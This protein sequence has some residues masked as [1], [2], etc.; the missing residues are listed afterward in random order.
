MSKK[1][2]IFIDIGNTNDLQRL[3]EFLN[4]LPYCTAIV[5]L[6]DRPKCLYYTDEI[7]KNTGYSKEEFEEFNESG[8]FFDKITDDEDKDRILSEIKNAT[9]EKKDFDCSFRY[10]DK[11]KEL[12][13]LQID[14][15]FMDSNSKNL[16]Y[17][18]T[19]SRPEE[20]ARLYKQ[21]VES[22]AFG[23]AVAERKTR[24]VLYINNYIL[25]S[26]F[27]SKHNFNVIG[28]YIEDMLPESDRFITRDEIDSLQLGKYKE[29]HR[30][31]GERLFEIRVGLINWNGADAY[32]AFIKDETQ[33][34]I[35]Q[36]RFSELLNSVPSGI[37][38][39]EVRNNEFNS[40]YLNDYFFNMIR[41]SR[42]AHEKL[43]AG[44]YIK[45]VHP[46]D[47]MTVRNAIRLLIE[48][49]DKYAFSYRQLCGDGKYIWLSLAVAVISRSKTAITA[50]CSYTDF[51]EVMQNR[52]VLEK[53]NIIIRKR[54][55]QELA[56]RDALQRHSLAFSSFNVTQNKMIEVKTN[57]DIQ[58]GM[59]SGINYDGMIKL[60][61]KTI[62]YDEDKVK[63]ET[64]LQ[65][66]NINKRFENGVTEEKVEYRSSIENK[67]T[68]IELTSNYF[69]EP[70][71]DDLIAYTF[72]RDIDDEKKTNIAIESVVDEGVD[73]IVLLKSATNQSRA[74][75]VRKEYDSPQQHLYSCVKTPPIP[76]SLRQM[77]E[78]DEPIVKEF[79][80]AE[81]LKSKLESNNTVS[82][83]YRYHSDN[84]ETMRKIAVAFYLDD[85]HDDIVIYI[86]DITDLYIEEQKNREILENAVDQANH[87]NEAKSEFLSRMSH[88][89]RTPM[90]GILGLTTLALESDNID[91][92]HKYL[93]ELNSSGT[94]LLGLLND[95]L[96]MSKI[97][98]GAI[99]LKPAPVDTRMFMSGLLAVIH[100]QAEEKGVIFE[101]DTDSS[102][103]VP[104]QVF[105]SLRVQQ[106]IMNIL[107]NAVK[108]TP[109]G[110]KVHYSYS[111]IETNGVIYCHHIISDTGIGM[112]DEFM[113]KMFDP[114]VQ[115]ENNSDSNSI[116]TGLGLSIC[117]KLTTIM[118]GTISVK[119]SIGKGSEFAVDIPT[120]I[121]SEEEYYEYTN[122]MFKDKKGEK[123][124]SLSGKKILICEDHP[125]NM[126]IAEKMLQNEGADVHTA[127]N[128]RLGV[129][130]F[131]ESPVGYY[132]CILM[133]IRMPVMDGLEAAKTIR[134]LKREDA[135]TVPVIAMSANVFPDDV[136]RSLDAGMNAHLGKPIEKQ[137]MISTIEKLI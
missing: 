52:H 87:A 50:Y 24:R 32:I 11:D 92:I 89:I 41:S 120:Q 31:K 49:M 27:D 47:V 83:T 57:N 100:A 69:K 56:R 94:Y 58:L 75:K 61:K 76:E 113:S 114:F 6:S 68:W 101:A 102:N 79:F 30:S 106:I 82:V 54:Y 112:S 39:Y 1:D 128:G 111:Y 55:E 29:Y 97:D 115:E 15:K 14:A 104:Y 71:T 127:T 59:V 66:K 124:S 13:W 64:F 108:F 93:L 103:D 22:S 38:I 10:T 86:K 135:A 21:I 125:V 4:Y 7:Y 136:K 109:S 33:D 63:L 81:Y 20:E 117:K 77:F 2:G 51:T 121:C 132:D 45:N 42:E 80:D 43:I 65:P 131:S 48:G 122:K 67:T 110:G 3:D 96:T 88:D 90:N 70:A 99:V 28:A 62:R 72:L 73:F 35:Q 98:E 74:V 118:G 107:N 8:N 123:G 91:E 85:T 19:F 18:C 129:D 137:K 34:K 16:I 23:V 105:D 116:G 44:D 25:G 119:S 36:K 40:V 78:E 26:I 95:I 130:M 5:E 17:L 12:K 60:L 126:L 37:G 46:D 53:T 133:D 9:A 84:G 134:E